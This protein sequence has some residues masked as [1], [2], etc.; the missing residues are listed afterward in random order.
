MPVEGRRG[1]PEKSF[2]E[3]WLCEL[4]RD[5]EAPLLLG[6]IFATDSLLF[7][8][9]SLIVGARLGEPMGIVTVDFLLFVIPFRL[10][11]NASNSS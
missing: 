7:G 5:S 1:T 3:Y 10:R 4:R 6:E 11:S 8:R 9:L 2:I